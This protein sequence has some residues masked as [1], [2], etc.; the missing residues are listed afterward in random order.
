MMSGEVA[1]PVWQMCRN[2]MISVWQLGMMCRGNP[3]K[4]AAPA[5]PASTIVVT[6][7]RTPPRSGW[8]P[9]R[10][11]PSKTCAC[12]S[13]RPGVTIFPPTSMVCVASADGMSLAMRAITPSRTA[14]SQGPSSPVDG[15]TTVPPLSKRSCMRF[16]R[17][18]LNGVQWQR[19]SSSPPAPTV[20]VGVGTRHGSA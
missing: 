1:S 11:T 20:K 8:T 7:A 14:M 5:L 15:S 10:L 19:E 6:P 16:S 9:L 3:A 18:L 2:G 12:R 17:L 13:M 4:V